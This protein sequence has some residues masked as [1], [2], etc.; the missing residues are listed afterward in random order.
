MNSQQAWKHL[1]RMQRVCMA[2][3][4]RITREEFLSEPLKEQRRYYNWMCQQVG[5]I[6]VGPYWN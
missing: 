5:S 3:G 4:S 1:D 2:K 6:T